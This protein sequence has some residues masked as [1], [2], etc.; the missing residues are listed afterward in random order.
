MTDEN[1]FL[2][3]FSA[4][5]KGGERKEG[6]MHLV[7]F[8]LLRNTFLKGQ[9]VCGS[10]TFSLSVDCVGAYALGHS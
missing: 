6:R 7:L 5:T 9:R 4:F 10:N 1:N 2:L 3:F 8:I